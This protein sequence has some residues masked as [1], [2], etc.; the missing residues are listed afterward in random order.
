[1]K[2]ADLDED[3]WLLWWVY[4]VGLHGKLS[5]GHQV[6]DMEHGSLM[7]GYDARALIEV[8]LMGIQWGVPRQGC[9]AGRFAS[10]TWRHFT[11]T[12][13][14]RLCTLVQQG[15]GLGWS[16]EQ[17]ME[18]SYYMESWG[19]LQRPLGRDMY[20]CWML[21]GDDSWSSWW[22]E[23]VTFGDFIY[24]GL[25]GSD[26]LKSWSQRLWCRMGCIISSTCMGMAWKSDL[27][28]RIDMRHFGV[29]ESWRWWCLDG[30]TWAWVEPRLNY[31]LTWELIDLWSWVAHG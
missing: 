20:A 13:M 21:V 1:M 11:Y 10:V 3:D 25:G 7:K 8:S 16:C 28:W 29:M 9:C 22:H 30:N 2:I 14:E 24:S 6:G 23:V 12:L 4:L 19:I 17:T 5:H 26:A 31:L 18:H 27:M 15:H